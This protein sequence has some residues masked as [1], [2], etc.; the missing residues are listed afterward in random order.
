M[1]YH[2][3]QLLRNLR[4]WLLDTQCSLFHKENDL[5]PSWTVSPAQLWPMFAYN[6]EESLHWLLDTK[7]SKILTNFDFKTHKTV[8]AYTLRPM[9]A[10]YGFRISSLKSFHGSYP[11]IIELP[12]AFEDWTIVFRSMEIDLSVSIQLTKI[13]INIS[14][15]LCLIPV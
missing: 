15:N 3:L 11:K 14:I 6:F 8:H 5:L 10:H 9:L 2:C 13:S 1:T 12:W 4:E 7:S